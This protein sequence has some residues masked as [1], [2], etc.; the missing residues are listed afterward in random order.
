MFSWILMCSPLLFFFQIALGNVCENP[1]VQIQK[2]ITN[3]ATMTA[4]KFFII[5]FKYECDNEVPPQLLRARINGNFISVVN[6]YDDKHQISW[7]EPMGKS[8]KGE[9]NITI[10]DEE[11]YS[12][13]KKRIKRQGNAEEVPAFLKFAINSPH[14]RQLPFIRLEFIVTCIC[15][16]IAY[17][18]IDYKRKI[19][20]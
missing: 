6:T 20:S 18:A 2:K 1:Q 10:Y 17:L 8:K 14:N 12:G 13:Y 9:R 15:T 3:D 11:G 4:E 7:A 5:E 16:T 19:I